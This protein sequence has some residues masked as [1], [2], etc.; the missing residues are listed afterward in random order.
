MRTVGRRCRRFSYRRTRAREALSVPRFVVRLPALLPRHALAGFLALSLLATGCLDDMGGSGGSR[1][2]GGPTRQ[3]GQNG[4]NGQDRKPKGPVCPTPGR[5]TKS[6]LPKFPSADAVSVINQNPCVSIAGLADQMIG[7]IPRGRAGEFAQF[8][9][10]LEQFIKRV[11]AA[12]D[13]VDCAY[14]TDHLAIEVYQ[15]DDWHWS[16]GMVAVVRGDLDALVDGAAC[17]LLKRVP[18]PTGGFGFRGEKREP[19]PAFCADAVSRKSKSDRFTVMWIGS[20][21]LMCK[22]LAYLANPAQPTP[23]SAG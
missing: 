1:P 19:D 11:N 17:W 6:Q 18:F 8:R 9:G 10:G 23:S 5:L 14:E 22:S 12:N 2:S 3:N 13:V 20:S 7:F 21:D 4:Q 15:H 16:L